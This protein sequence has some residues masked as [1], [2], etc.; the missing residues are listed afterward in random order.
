[1][2]PAAS[3]ERRRLARHRSTRRD[4]RLEAAA[5]RQIARIGHRALDRASRCVARRR[6]RDELR[7]PTRVGVLRLGEELADTALLDHPA[8]IHDD[9][10]VG[11]L[12]DDAEIVGDE[13][14]RHADARAA[15]RA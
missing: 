10:L 6:A 14:D 13:Q 15:A 5:G 12:G 7:R 2:A 1:M 11:D 3:I 8:G 9:D 4:R